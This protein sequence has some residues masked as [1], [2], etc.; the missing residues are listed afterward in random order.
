MIS[1]EQAIDRLEQRESRL[2]DTVP[3]FRKH[4]PAW[5][6]RAE[7]AVRATGRALRPDEVDVED[8]ER[9]LDRLADLVSLTFV[10]PDDD[11]DGVD[12][13]LRLPSADDDS[14]RRRP[15]TMAEILAWVEAGGIDPLGKNLDDRDAG[16]DPWQI[17]QGVFFAMR[18]DPSIQ[19]NTLRE[20]IAK[21]TA[22]TPD[23]RNLLDAIIRIW[24]AQ[25]GPVI[26]RDWKQWVSD[27][28]RL[29]GAQ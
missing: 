12:I 23:G 13:D 6:R 29:R 15:V 18:K 26:R 4:A 5:R 17:A 16:K 14:S 19:W 11:G 21:R 20:F 25:L 28:V 27:Q 9:Y 7:A 3:F 22:E 1:I 24:S 2:S 8:W 10:V